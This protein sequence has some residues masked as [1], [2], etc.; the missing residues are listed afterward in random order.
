MSFEKYV[1][2]RT[3]RAAQVSIKKTGTISLDS[4]F[5]RAFGFQKVNYVTLH[6]DAARKLVGVKPEANSKEEGAIKLSHR[7]RVSSVRARAFFEAFG[8]KI[9]STMRYPIA[10]DPDDSM[11]VIALEGM[12]RKRGPRPKQG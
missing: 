6:F 5:A 11:A 10:F 3:Q 7:T 1:P 4:A 12:K 9:E 2:L 8:M